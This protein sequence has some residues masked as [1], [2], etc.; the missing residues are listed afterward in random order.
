MSNAQS[1]EF[2]QELGMPLS[3]RHLGRTFPGRIDRRHERFEDV[4][5]FFAETMRLGV[6]ALLQPSGLADQVGQA[7]EA[8]V[9]LAVDPI[10]VS[11]RPMG[12]LLA[13]HAYDHLA[14]TLADHEQARGGAGEHPQP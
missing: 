10:A 12:E 2:P 7:S 1:Q 3:Q 5:G 6:K 9:V 4:E 13:E 11:H 14:G 8:P